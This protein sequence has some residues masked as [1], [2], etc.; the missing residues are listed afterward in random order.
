MHAP[1]RPY[2]R[3]VVQPL[4][5]L[6][7]ASAEPHL[8]WRSPGWH[9]YLRAVQNKWHHSSWLIQQPACWAAPPGR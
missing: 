4:A 9:E 8:K 3:Q 2:P 7:A 1:N 5:S 6:A